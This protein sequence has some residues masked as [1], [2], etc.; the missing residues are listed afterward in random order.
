MR[1]TCDTKLPL[2]TNSAMAAC[3]SHGLPLF[4]NALAARTASARRRRHDHV[5][6]PQ[7]GPEGLRERA[8]MDGAVRRSGGQRGGGGAFVAEIRAAI[9]FDDD[10]PGA[11]CPGDDLV[12]APL[13]ERMAGRVLVCRRRVQQRGRRRGQL[14]GDESL[15]IDRHACQLGPGSLERRGGGAV[16]GHFHRRDRSRA[17]QQAGCQGDALRGAAGDHDLPRLRD[18]AARGGEVVG[19]RG[20]QRRQAERID[21]LRQS[22][23]G[24][25]SQAGA[26]QPAPCL[27]GEQ[28]RIRP[29]GGE[30]ERQAVADRHRTGGETAAT[31]ARG[32][33]RGCERSRG[34]HVTPRVRYGARSPA[35]TGGRARHR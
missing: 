25:L 33:R 8:E 16:A 30:I 18:D 2:R 24:A 23:G 34:R 28:R 7:A 20:P 19:D 5:A 29:A 27:Q 4:S 14:G 10:A 32:D 3:S 11:P 12:A 15:V 13:R 6:Q 26:Q 1:R 35:V 31:R 22:G 21:R 17:Q 9:V